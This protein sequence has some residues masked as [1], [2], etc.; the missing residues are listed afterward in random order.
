MVMMAHSV[1][2]TN[3]SRRIRYAH[4]HFFNA[5]LRAILRLYSIYHQSVKAEGKPGERQAGRIYPSGPRDL[6]HIP[7]AACNSS[8]LIPDRARGQ[9]AEACSYRLSGHHFCNQRINHR[10]FTPGAEES[11]YPDA[12]EICRSEL[13][14]GLAAHR[15]CIIQ[16]RLRLRLVTG[17]ISTGGYS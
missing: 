8:V 14:H 3:S 7:S 13:G 9:A 11:I 6:A 5:A 10:A 12:R 4:R 17:A 1:G 2:I 15:V 16:S